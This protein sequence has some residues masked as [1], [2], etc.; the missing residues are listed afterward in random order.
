[1]PAVANRSTGNVTRRLVWH[2][3]GR[4]ML[5]KGDHVPR[6]EVHHHRR[7]PRELRGPLAEEE[8]G[9]RVP[10]GRRL[11]GRAV[12]HPGA[13]RGAE[14]ARGARRGRR[15][16]DDAHR[17]DAA[18]R[19]R[20]RRS[21]GRDAM[22]CVGAIAS[23]SCRRPARLPRGCTSSRFSARSAKGKC[24]S[25]AE[26]RV[27]ES[28]RSDTLKGKKLDRRRDPRRGDRLRSAMR[29]AGGRRGGMDY[30]K[31]PEHITWNSDF[32][33]CRL[34]YRQS[35]RMATA[36]GGASIIRAPT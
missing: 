24:T 33:F 29:S 19:V 12:L 20:G 7:H 36:A 9:A 16:D 21:V 15:G 18:A 13:A 28:C 17:R 1:M 34:A 22:D 32:T 23:P 11:A 3:R 8:P 31:R 30:V 35:Q 5:N 4:Y 2:D 27:E 10:V 14:G 25:V 26:S 6:F